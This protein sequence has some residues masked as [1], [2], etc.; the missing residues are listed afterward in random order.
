MRAG[1]GVGVALMMLSWCVSS[2]G[3]A[4]VDVGPQ[5]GACTQPGWPAGIVELVRHDARV[6]SMWVN[7]RETFYY[8]ADPDQMRKLIALFSAS[9]MRDHRLQIKFGTKT[10]QSFNGDRIPYNVM[11]AVEGMSVWAKSQP[12]ESRDTHEPA[13]TIYVDPAKDSAVLSYIQA[14]SNITIHMETAAWPFE[15]KASQSTREVWCARV[16]FDDAT[17]ATDLEH[18]VHT[19]V[20]LWEQGFEEGILLGY[21]CGDG[22]FCAGFSEQELAAL[23]SGASWLTLTTGNWTTDAKKDDPRLDPEDLAR[24]PQDAGTVSIPNPA[25]YYGRLLFEDGSPALLDPAP[26]PHA[27]IQVNF[28]YAGSAHLDSEGYFRVY[29]TPEQYEAVRMEKVHRNIY[30]PSYEQRGSASA[31]YTFPAADLSQDKS[32]AGVVRIPR[33]KEMIRGPGSPLRSS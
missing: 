19:K 2:Y 26:G 12:D 16:Q 33:P 8:D 10:T 18:G 14:L 15:E 17:P 27:K 23:K 30:I 11:L 9:R 24:D 31:L 1:H 20:T 7:G 4:S 25:F 22:V 21:V 28:P 3:A 6:Y 32:K 29:F 13:M 5:T